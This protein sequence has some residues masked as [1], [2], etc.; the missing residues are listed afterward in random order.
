M[1]ICRYCNEEI[2][3]KDE[4]CGNCGYNPRTD[5][6]TTSFVKKEKQTKSGQKQKIVSPGVKSFAFWGMMVIVF[7]LGIKYQG[8]I[9]DIIWQAKNIVLGNKVN[10]S[11]KA[12]AKSKQDK[13]IKLIDVRSYQRPADKSSGKDIKIEGIFYDPQAKSY[14]VINGQLISEK[15][16]FGGMVIKKINTDSVEVIQG[17]RE[18]ILR[19]NQ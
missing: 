17:G 12:L 1:K 11:A 7:S 4:V 10:K 5:T 9:G 2:G 19:V 18:Q 15:E 3:E 16:S 14:V 8:K 13:I 6:L